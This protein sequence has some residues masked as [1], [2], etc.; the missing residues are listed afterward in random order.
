[1]KK[2]SINTSSGYVNW[3]PKL[4]GKL[5]GQMRKLHVNLIAMISSVRAAILLGKLGIF[6]ADCADCLIGPILPTFQSS[7]SAV[8]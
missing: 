3:P 2:D 1:M 5:G 4:G 8:T 7:K 6:V